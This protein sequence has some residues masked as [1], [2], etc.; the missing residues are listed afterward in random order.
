[1]PQHPAKRTILPSAVMSAHAAHPAARSEE[2]RVG[3]ECR[4]PADGDMPD[5]E[6]A[7]P[8]MSQADPHSIWQM[9]LG[10]LELEMPSST[11]NTWVRDTWVLGYEDGEF[12]IGLPNAYARDWLE[13]RL[14]FKI[15][16]ALASMM[17]R[18]V[19]VRFQIVPRP[20]RAAVS[21]IASSTRITP[22]TPLW[23][24]IITGWRM[25][26]PPQWPRNQGKA[27]ILSLS[28]V[29]LV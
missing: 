18:Q 8:A 11:F 5:E 10:E 2:R 27:I 25:P 21:T 16:R 23:S 4:P 1:M 15:K 7:H 19:Q 22:S 29:V 24:A 17:Q 3:K 6:G 26:P 28:M 20:D 13:N 12:L 14:R 9:L